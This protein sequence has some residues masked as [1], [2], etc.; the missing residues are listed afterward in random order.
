MNISSIFVFKILF[1][2]NEVW[3]AVE[4]FKNEEI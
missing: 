3:D 4:Q 1:L 2:R